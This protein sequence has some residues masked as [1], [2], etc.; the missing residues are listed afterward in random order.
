MCLHDEASGLFG[1]QDVCGGY[2]SHLCGNLRSDVLHVQP[3]G[4]MVSRRHVRTK[5]SARVCVLGVR[6]VCWGSMTFDYHGG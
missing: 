2:S 1:L 3:S 4:R 6:L 5:S